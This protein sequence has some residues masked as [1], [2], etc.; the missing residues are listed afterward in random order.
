MVIIASKDRCMIREALEVDA[1]A[2]DGGTLSRGQEGWRAR[3][4]LM[5][6]L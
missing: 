5:Q 6:T 2:Q 3:P 1:Q 4:E